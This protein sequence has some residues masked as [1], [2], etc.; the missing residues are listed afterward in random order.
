MQGN[1][2]NLPLIDNSVFGSLPIEETRMLT[3]DELAALRA[4]LGKIA[5]YMTSV[6]PRKDADKPR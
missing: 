5:N 2:A 6:L 3:A 1:E 4:S